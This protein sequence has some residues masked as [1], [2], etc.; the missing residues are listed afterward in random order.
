MEL[1]EICY[2]ATHTISQRSLHSHWPNLWK[3][4]SRRTDTR[5]PRAHLLG[6]SP[7]YGSCVVADSECSLKVNVHTSGNM[8]HTIY[9]DF[10]GWLRAETQREARKVS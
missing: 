1:A 7:L 3:N 4:Y 9:V 2:V 8:R 10:V 5:S 6:F